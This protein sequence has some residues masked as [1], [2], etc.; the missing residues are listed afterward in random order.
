[1]NH[2][3]SVLKD[4]R[5]VEEA[6]KILADFKPVDYDVKKFDEI[7]G[8]FEKKAVDAAKATVAKVSSEEESLRATLS[9]I[10]DARPFE[11]LT[12]LEVGKAAPEVTKAVETAIKKGR[13][14]V[15]G[16]REIYGGSPRERRADNRRAVVDVSGFGHRKPVCICQRGGGRGRWDEGRGVQLGKRLAA[17]KSC[18]WPGRGEEGLREALVTRRAATAGWARRGRR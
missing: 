12:T 15:P 18:A 14:T 4:Q 6:S 10:K 7:V 17:P 2:Y 5:A 11:D 8:A 3:K 9:N 13:W 16:Y 1:M